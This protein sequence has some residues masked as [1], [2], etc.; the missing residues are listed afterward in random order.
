MEQG[1]FL[2]ACGIETRLKQLS[3]SLSVST[4]A[5]LA[6]GVYRLTDPSQMGSIY[7]VFAAVNK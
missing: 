1:H 6:S 7:K 3:R 5:E 4:T 2:K